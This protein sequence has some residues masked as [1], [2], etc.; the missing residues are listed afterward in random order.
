MLTRSRR[1]AQVIQDHCPAGQREELLTKLGFRFGYSGPHA[2]RAMMLDDLRRLLADVAPEA[3]RA[4]YASAVIDAN[5]LGKP[6]RKARELALRHLATRYAPEP[7]NP[8]FRVL[9]RP[10]LHLVLEAA[11]LFV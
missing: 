1:G 3:G 10:P 4:E 2:A 9:R 7:S 8:V 6:T 11:Q 5:R